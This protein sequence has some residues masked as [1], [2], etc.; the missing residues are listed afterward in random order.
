[1]PKNSYQ[2]IYPPAFPTS[3]CKYHLTK[4]HL[5]VSHF[6]GLMP[7]CGMAPISVSRLFRSRSTF[8]LGVVMSCLAAGCATIY[9][10]YD[11]TPA[12]AVMVITRHLA[13]PDQYLTYEDY[14]KLQHATSARDHVKDLKR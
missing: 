3:I 4:Q 2:P 8:F 6:T 12:G 10:R 5:L 1:M 13:S 7:R 9:V 11:D 14:T